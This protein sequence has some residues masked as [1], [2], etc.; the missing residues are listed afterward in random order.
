LFCFAFFKKT[1]K[2]IKTNKPSIGY[3]L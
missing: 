1:I 3:G 2:N